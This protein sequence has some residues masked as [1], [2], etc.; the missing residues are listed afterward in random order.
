[1]F[2]FS[3]MLTVLPLSSTSSFTFFI[4]ELR[5]RSSERRAEE[6]LEEDDDEMTAVMG[7]SGF[8]SKNNSH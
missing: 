5:L 1:M 2:S 4:V 3:K 8:R 7:F 6:D